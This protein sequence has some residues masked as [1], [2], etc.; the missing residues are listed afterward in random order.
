[1]VGER[2]RGAA[3]PP[4][5]KVTQEARCGWHFGRA[6]QCTLPATIYPPGGDHPAKRGLCTWHYECARTPRGEFGHDAFIEFLGRWSAYCSFWNHHHPEA[7]WLATQGSPLPAGAELRTC[8]N[9]RCSLAGVE[10]P[11]SAGSFRE[12]S[13]EL[14]RR[15]IER[16]RKLE[17][18]D[19]GRGEEAAQE[20][21]PF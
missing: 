14:T 6:T 15:M 17:E 21:V 4:A 19:A 8:G 18:A 10:E 16:A 3:G 7:L 2:G 1:M 13:E 12:L 9:A 11:G 5:D 20:E